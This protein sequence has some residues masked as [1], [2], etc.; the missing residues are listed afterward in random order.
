LMKAKK[1]ALVK[2]AMGINNSE[3]IW[4]IVKWLNSIKTEL[5]EPTSISKTDA[6]IKTTPLDE[7]LFIQD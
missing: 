3:D 7:S 1:N 4:K 5:G 2:I 6:T